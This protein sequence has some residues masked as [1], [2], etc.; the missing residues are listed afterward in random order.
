MNITQRSEA[1]R[2][3]LCVKDDKFNYLISCPV[4]EKLRQAGGDYLDIPEACGR[5]AMG[6]FVPTEEMSCP[7]EKIAQIIAPDMEVQD[8]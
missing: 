5:L 7:L 2:N 8:A 4:G 6:G 1:R 3:T